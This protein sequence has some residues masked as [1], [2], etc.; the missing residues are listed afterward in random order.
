MKLFL[1]YLI[2]LSAF[3]NFALAESISMD[4]ARQ[5]YS[6]AVKEEDKLEL[7]LVQ[8][9][10]IKKENPALNGV[11]TVYI[12]SLTMLK[13]KHAFWPHKKVEYV[14]DGIKIMDKGL[15]ADPNNLESLFIYGSSCRYLPFFLGKKDLAIEKL[16]KMLTLLDDISIK[17]YN[18][19]FLLNAMKFITEKVDLSPDEKAK[20]NLY[21][22]KIESLK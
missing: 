21:I 3:L 16:K 13:G 2:I 1:L 19:D 18:T 9:E 14:N 15:N 7:A 5:L 11:A 12:G 17:K 20:V 6:Q 8:Y 10:Q 4:S 22:S